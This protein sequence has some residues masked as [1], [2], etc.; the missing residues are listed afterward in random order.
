MT[1][2]LTTT[3]KIMGGVIIALIF[4]FLFRECGHQR[5]ENNLVNNIANYKDT[6]KFDK[7][8]INEQ[9][10]AIAYNA[11]L[12]LENKDQLESLLKKHDTLYAMIKKFKDVK[13]TTIINQYTTINGDTIPLRDSI[14]CDFKAFKVRRDSIYYHFVGTIAPKYFSIDSL[15]IPNKQSIIVGTKKLGFL[16]GVEERAEIVN[17]N[18]LIHIANI[19]SYV[20]NKKKKRFG[21]G[22]SVGYG[23]SLN[24]NI[25]RTSPYIGVSANYNLFEF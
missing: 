19:E 12:Q 7:I 24:G 2:Q 11:S 13:S 15:F 5:D 17:S 22:A 4:F 20:L 16:R 25:V 1:L 9:E 6:V 8:K 18:P 3:E 10:V 23:F 21:I 14:P